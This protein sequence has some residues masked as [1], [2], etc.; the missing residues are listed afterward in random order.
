MELQAQYVTLFRYFCNATIVIQ[1]LKQSLKSS[2][3]NLGK[4]FLTSP[5]FAQV[6]CLK[7]FVVSKLLIIA[8]QTM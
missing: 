7:T 5:F 4:V 1:K 6:S 8:A 3:I 2:F